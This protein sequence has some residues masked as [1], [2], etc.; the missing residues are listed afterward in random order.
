MVHGGRSFTHVA[1]RSSEGSVRAQRN[2]VPLVTERRSDGLVKRSSA[3]FSRASLLFFPVATFSIVAA[4]L[5]FVLT[6][7]GLVLPFPFLPNTPYAGTKEEK[8]RTCLCAAPH[9]TTHLCDPPAAQTLSHSQS[10]F[11]RVKGHL[12]M[13][14]VKVHVWKKQQE[15]NIED[16]V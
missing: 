2:N 13:L 3:A 4:F 14:T 8:S 12:L 10:G 1:L 9:I 7:V 15:Y 16:T 6:S 11:T 5:S